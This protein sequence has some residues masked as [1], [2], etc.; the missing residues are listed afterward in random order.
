VLG[1]LVDSSYPVQVRRHITLMT[2]AR[3]WANACYRFAPPFLAV[4]ARDLDVSLDEVGLALAISEAAGLSSPLMGR[5]VDRLP[6]RVATGGGLAGVALGAALA[7]ASQ[8]MW[9]FAAALVA[10]NQS[11]IVFD[12][13]LASW[14]ADYVPYAKRGRIV[15]LTETSWALGLLIGVSALGVV[16]ALSSWRFG[17]I[18][19]AVAVA[20][21]GAAVALRLPADP[22]AAHDAP[23]ARPPKA[24][25]DW[26]IAWRPITG[27][28]VLMASSQC[29][30][31]TFGT[32]LK[33]EFGLGA[34]ALSAVTFTLGGVELVASIT[35][36]RRS[37]T[38]GK[39]T[40]AAVGAA[41]M[42][43]AM[44]ALA[45]WHEQLA[46]GIVLL[47]ITLLGFEFA[48]V[49]ALPI[50]TQLIPS[51]PARGL[52]IML[53]A[54]TVGRALTSLAATRLYTAHGVAG[55]MLLGVALAAAAAGVFSGRGLRR[56]VAARI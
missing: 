6:R 42:V 15:G 14:V 27:A 36:A 2:V 12:L 5:V 13:G 28:F 41:V 25:L 40:S 19:G 34:A 7:A 47:A 55:P 24:P 20:A 30:F 45:L 44:L 39:E 56:G 11:K 38:W 8:G 3:L 51:A 9:L 33:D 26:S 35:A 4:I 37:D 16:T 23:S 48:I 1:R 52:G 22:A 54:A 17:F 32:W 29:L 21:M 10:L 43:P 49:S 18:G 31:V 50:G 46:V 53:A